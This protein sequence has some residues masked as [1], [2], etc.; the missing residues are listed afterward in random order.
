LDLAIRTM[1]AGYGDK[2]CLGGVGN[3]GL[4]SRCGRNRPESHANDFE[5]MKGGG[6]MFKVVREYAKFALSTLSSVMY[7][8]T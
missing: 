3:W 5:S 6:H 1:G 4:S 7:H 8:T 2:G